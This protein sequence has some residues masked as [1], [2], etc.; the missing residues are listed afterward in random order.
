MTSGTSY[1]SNNLTLPAGLYLGFMA[2][3]P[4]YF[5]VNGVTNFTNLNFSVTGTNVT[6]IVSYNDGNIP[7]DPMIFGNA[8]TYPSMSL[9]P[10]LFSVSA[11]STNIRYQFSPTFSFDL[12]PAGMSASNSPCTYL[13]IA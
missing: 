8:S 9:G 12:N 7:R 3:V 10:I 6:S 1:Y 13:R 2:F 5:G 4:N 11:S